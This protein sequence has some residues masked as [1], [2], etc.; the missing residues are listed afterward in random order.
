MVK[1]LAALPYA[2]ALAAASCAARRQATMSRPVVCGHPRL[3]WRRSAVMLPSSVIRRTPKV[4]C[5]GRNKT[6]TTSLAAAL[7]AM[8]YRLGNQARAELLMED[9]AQRDFRR[10]V[11][12]CRQ[13]E[14]FQ[15]VPFSL[16][17][18]YQ[19]VDA[20]FPGSRFVLTIRDDPRTWYESVIRFHTK[21]LGG[22]PTAEA[23]KRDPYRAPGWIWRNQHLIYGTDEASVFDRDVFVRHYERHNADVVEYFRHRPDDLLVVNLSDEGAGERLS[24][25]LGRPAVE[26]P[27]LNR[28]R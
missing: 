27:H 20:A 25:F 3:G 9:W 6:G 14:A 26:I 22:P 8:G 13:A 16:P 24:A 5:I 4:F 1:G 19:A 23:L 21:R 11:R 18:T 17:Y 7:R 15:D 2:A 12:L 10:I 28:S